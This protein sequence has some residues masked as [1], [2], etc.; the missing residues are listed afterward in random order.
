MHQSGEFLLNYLKNMETKKIK[1]KTGIKHSKTH[2]GLC[3]NKGCFNVRKHCSKYCQEC[4]EK[5]AKSN[6]VIHNT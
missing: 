3:M 5:Y 6:L 4:S 2:L 1:Y